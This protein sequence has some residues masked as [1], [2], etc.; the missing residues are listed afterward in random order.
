LTDSPIGLAASM[1]DRDADSYQKISHAF[2]DGQPAGRLTRDHILDNMTL[3]RLTD[4]ATSSARM[5]WES[6]Q[7]AAAAAGRAPPPVSLPVAFTVFPGEI[8]RRRAVGLRRST[9]T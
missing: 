7:S 4:T 2:L 1:L 6:A 5:Y 8:F 3:Y 9:P